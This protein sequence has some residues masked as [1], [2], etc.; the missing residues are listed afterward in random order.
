MLIQHLQ[1]MF[2][3]VT[4]LKNADKI[5]QYY[6]PEFVLYANGHIMNYNEFLALHQ[7]LYLT[8]I[9]YEIEY[10]EGTFL[11]QG[12][13]VAGRMWITIQSSKQPKRQLEVVL[14]AEFKNHQ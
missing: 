12:E 10:D 6:H 3:E 1:R 5:P 11:E 2:Q 7:K 9:Q 4:V 13:K 8:D 14:I